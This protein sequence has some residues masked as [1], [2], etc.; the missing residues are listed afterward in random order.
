MFTLTG[1][2]IFK[3]NWY[4]LEFPKST[5]TTDT[6]NKL[7]NN[8]YGENVYDISNNFHVSIVKGEFPS[9]KIKNFGKSFVGER[10]TVT[11]DDTTLY[12]V[13]GRHVWFNVMNDRMCEIREFFGV[14][15][16]KVDSKYKVKF[17]L[18]VAKFI[19]PR[20]SSIDNKKEMRISKFSHIDLNDMHQ[21]V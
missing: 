16:V 5:D 7:L 19:T 1:Q 14:P 2:V 8:K 4:L 10:I 13:N 18:T 17:H 9:L 11:I 20:I 15:C 3:N 21:R 6:I 12:D